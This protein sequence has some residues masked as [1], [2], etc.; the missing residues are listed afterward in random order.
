MASRAEGHADPVLPSSFRAACSRS[1]RCHQQSKPLD[2]SAH[3]KRYD[4][5]WRTIGFWRTSRPRFVPLLPTYGAT[6]T[7]GLITT[8]TG[9]ESPRTPARADVENTNHQGGVSWRAVYIYSLFASTSFPVGLRNQL[10]VHF[11]SLLALPLVGLL[12]HKSLHFLHCYHD[13]FGCRHRVPGRLRRRLPSPGISSAQP[14]GI[15]AAGCWRPSRHTTA[16]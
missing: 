10:S 5:V 2:A 14:S 8:A 12:N 3:F 4:A 6:S 7:S 15:A 13:T 16:L 1:Y 9:S 11:P